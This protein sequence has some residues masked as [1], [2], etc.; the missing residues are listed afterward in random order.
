M[1][2]VTRRTT[3]N[4]MKPL[5]A[6]DKIGLGHGP[7]GAGG[8]LGGNREPGHLAMNP[9]VLVPCERITGRSVVSP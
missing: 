3:A 7:A 6:A 9:M 4:V 5:W 1:R 2:D 8:K